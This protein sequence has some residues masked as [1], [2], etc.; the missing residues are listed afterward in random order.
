MD[1]RDVEFYDYGITRYQEGALWVVA[2][3]E[4]LMSRAALD[5]W[6]AVCVDL[7]HQA[8][9]GVPLRL[10]L[11]LTHKGMGVTPYLQKR[12]QD[13]LS[14]LPE[15]GQAYIALV[16]K[17]S[18]LFRLATLMLGRAPRAP[19]SA[20]LHLFANVHEAQTWLQHPE[21]P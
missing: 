15:H 17:D 6:Y 3:T 16:I 1:R 8:L 12:V 13:I 10:L 21:Q 9:P 19:Q 2:N 20:S 5:Q 7:I 11:D 4:G 14:A 18:L